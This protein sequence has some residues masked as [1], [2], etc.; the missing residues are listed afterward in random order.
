MHVSRNSWLRTEFVVQRTM[1]KARVGLGIQLERPRPLATNKCS[2][3]WSAACDQ[4]AMP[5][6]EGQTGISMTVY[7]QEGLFAKPFGNGMRAR[8]AL[9]LNPHHCPLTFS[10][11]VEAETALVALPLL[12]SIA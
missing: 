9:L 10:S 8:H 6:L 11:D 7:L 3:V 2:D 12:S 4:V 5:K 1:V